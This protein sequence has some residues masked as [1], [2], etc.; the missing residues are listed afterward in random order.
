M[1]DLL[2]AHDFPPLGG[3]IARLL[4]EVALRTDWIVS[5]GSLPNA[6][7]RPFA[8][9][10]DR[11]PFPA[12]R[13][14]NLPGLLAWRR[15]AGGLVRRHRPDAIWV[16]NIRPAGAVAASTARRHQIPHRILV[17]GGDLLQLRER[18]RRH[19]LRA[20][21]FGWVLGGAASIIAISRW[22]A[23]LA[24][25]VC[26]QLGL[27]PSDKLVTVPLGS[28]PA[29][30]RPR[31]PDPALR[32]KHRL[33]DRRWLLTVARLAPHKGID[34]G[35]EV[36]ARLGA[37]HPDLGYLVVGE[38]PD[39]A[40]LRDRA[41]RAGVLDRMVFLEGVPDD[42]VPGLVSLATL[43]L[44]LSREEGLDVEGF[45]IALVDAAAAGLAVVAG[46]SGGTA[47]AVRDGETGILVPPEEPAAIAVAVAHLLSDPAR[48]RAYGEAGRRWVEADRNWDRVVRDLLALSRPGATAA[49]R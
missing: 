43:Y 19:P 27:D 46:R 48:R 31:A 12:H 8:G 17:Y 2:L 36:L 5:T 20:P 9:R 16:G 49:R 4:A 18:I 11:L 3:G 42:E 14:K 28:D 13:L 1:S 30:F 34:I 44:G 38:G 22:T 24:A 41:E 40:R 45:G 23:R 47:D 15:R 6:D 32:A 10:V 29:R 33:P 7:D 39:R 21:L 35:I 37:A 26:A 25:E